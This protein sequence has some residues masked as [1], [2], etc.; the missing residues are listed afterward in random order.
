MFNFIKEKISELNKN[1]SPIVD[2]SKTIIEYA[3][4]FQEL[5]DLSVSG[6]DE[7]KS[8]PGGIEI[9]LD[10]DLEL[11]SVEMNLSDGRITDIPMDATVQESNYNAMKTFED[12]YQE[13]LTRVCKFPRESYEDV[14]RRRIDYASKEF[15]KYKNHI[16][17][18]GLFGF[19]KIK[20]SDDRLPSKVSVDFGPMSPNTPNQHY[21]VKMSV[22]YEVDKKDRVL[23]KQLDSIN[24]AM[25]IGIGEP[26]AKVLD[27][28][29]RKNHPENMKDVKSVWDV[30][31]PV[32]LI[33]PV[34]PIDKYRVMFG[35][36]CEFIEEIIYFSWYSD[37]KNSKNSRHKMSESE[38]IKNLKE[39]SENEVKKFNAKSKKEYIKESQELMRP[40]RFSN[41]FQEAID[42]G[43]VGDSSDPPE[44]SD[45]SSEPSVSF[46]DTSSEPSDT[47]PVE[48]NSNGEDNTSAV[49]VDSNNVSD[50]I[51]EKVAEDQQS[52]DSVTD[53]PIDDELGDDSTNETDIDEKLDDL[54]DSGNTD[55]D[56]DEDMENIDVDN[57]TIEDLLE[58]G[59]EKLKGMTIQQL[60][61]F[62]S[63][64]PS[65]I[66]EA[67]VL[68]KKNINK[69]VDIHL[70]KTLGILNDSEMSFDELVKNFKKEGSKLNR[71]LSK[72]SKSKKV[73][74][75]DEIKDIIKLNK[76]LIDLMSIIGSSQD[77]SYATT[78]KRLIQAFT[79]QSVVVSKIIESK[80]KP[81]S[82]SES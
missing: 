73:Y 20:L 14:E 36:E 56:L 80:S 62:L 6:T 48:D 49:P 77:K 46:D 18:E 32:K 69:E 51:A 15:N 72:A 82:V 23:K 19:D 22:L 65:Q 47:A 38:S 67:F 45:N 10:D 17:Q 11:D 5:D 68:S 29:L 3:H 54:D 59:S 2:D 37:I 39:I 1:D 40:D 57:M 30:A 61:E 76:C 26:L 81:K 13:S 64:D 52:E 44:N 50:Q 25:S 70:R 28:S 53:I 8:R 34:D 42:F 58:Q 71:V 27:E 55:M 24:I 60:K 78:V 21:I 33:I 16:I 31:T 9:P 7:G 12:F 79:S 75:D 41:F 63:G 74:T 66:Q 4:L 43:D 35:F